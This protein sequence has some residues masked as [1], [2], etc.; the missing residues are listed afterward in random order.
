[1][2]DY[3]SYSEGSDTFHVHYIIAKNKINT[4]KS[5]KLKGKFFF[6]LRKILQTSSSNNS[7]Q[8]NSIPHL[9]TCSFKQHRVNYKIK[10]KYTKLTETLK[11]TALTELDLLQDQR[12]R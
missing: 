2:E 8:F 6:Y 10:T 4:V 11:Q 3:I 5:T 9:S 1:L 7:I 12:L